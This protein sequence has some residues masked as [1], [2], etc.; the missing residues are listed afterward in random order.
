MADKKI[1][2]NKVMIKSNLVDEI[3]PGPS[4]KYEYVISKVK[5]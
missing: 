4:G 5:Y 1:M 2:K 3:L